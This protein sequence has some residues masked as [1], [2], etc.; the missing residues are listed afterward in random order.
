VSKKK[1]SIK[2]G[3][4]S[5]IFNEAI[6]FSVP[7]YKLNSIQIRLTV[8]NVRD[9]LSMAGRNQVILYPLGHLIVGSGTSGKG[10]RHWHQMLTSMRKPVAMWHPLR[11]ISSSRPHK[12]SDLVDLT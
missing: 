8:V 3:D 11:R 5:Q 1:T 9:E 2:R 7:P 6:I 12:S 10:L 4:K